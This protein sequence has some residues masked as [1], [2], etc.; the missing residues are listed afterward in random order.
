MLLQISIVSL[1]S[2]NKTF[3][4]RNIG[5]E[6]PT[7]NIPNHDKKENIDRHIN[8]SKAIMLERALRAYNLESFR[9]K[10]YFIGLFCNG[11]LP[12]QKNKS[13]NG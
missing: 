3:D 11:N 2:G 13:R 10:P 8:F 9:F 7:A 12:G 4:I 1:V 6:I 5:S